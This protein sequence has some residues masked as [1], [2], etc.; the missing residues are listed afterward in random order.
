MVPPVIDDGTRN[1]TLFKLGCSLRGKGISEAAIWAALQ[2]EN[3][4]KCNPPLNERELENIFKQVCKYPEGHP[5]NTTE[6]ENEIVPFEVNPKA[7]PDVEL[8]TGLL[9]IDDRFKRTW[10]HRRKDF[11]NDAFEVYEYSLARQGRIVE[12]PT[13]EIINLLIFHRRR[14]GAPTKDASY[15]RNVLRK[16]SRESGKTDEEALS[17]AE[18]EEALTKGTE[19]ILALIRDRLGLPF[20]NL[21]KRGKQQARYSFLLEDGEEIALGPVEILMQPRIVRAKI[22]EVTLTVIKTFKEEEWRKMVNLFGPLT[23]QIDVGGDRKE[24]LRGWINQYLDNADQFTFP[25]ALFSSSPVIEDGIAYVNV[26][27]FRK[28]LNR[29]WNENADDKGIRS[30]LSEYGFTQ[31][32]RVGRVKGKLYGRSYWKIAYTTLGQAEEL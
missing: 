8:F 15:Y 25:D 9:E 24:T 32:T 23:V 6:A 13:Q 26:M 30:L 19:A 12:W 2:E 10:E 21:I 1:D 17:E 18:T 14:Y 28:Y 5:E 29:K 7:G 22:F 4:Q 20:K 16:T 27:A 11:K 3:K 31:I